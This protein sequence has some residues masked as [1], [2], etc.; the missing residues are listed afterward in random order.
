MRSLA[1]FCLFCPLAPCLRHVETVAA[2]RRPHLT[3]LSQLCWILF[4]QFHF[5]RKDLGIL[6]SV[7]SYDESRSKWLKTT[8]VL[9]DIAGVFFYQRCA[10]NTPPKAT[11]WDHTRQSMKLGVNQA[12]TFMHIHRTGKTDERNSTCGALFPAVAISFGIELA[13]SLSFFLSFFLSSFFRSF[14]L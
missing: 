4:V 2:S 8:L 7:L 12:N 11:T 13:R 9:Q 3:L 10:R 1:L 5:F 14:F 6:E